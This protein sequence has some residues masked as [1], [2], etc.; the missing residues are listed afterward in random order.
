[1]NVFDAVKADLVAR[2]TI[3]ASQ[4]G[5]RELDALEPGRDWLR[6]AYEE[7]LDMAVY[8]R[9]EIA[10]RAAED[11]GLRTQDSVAGGGYHPVVER[12]VHVV[13]AGALIWAL[14]E[15]VARW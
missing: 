13:L 11:S 6:E 3:G 15:L 9:A 4:H 10:R 2:E 8:L 5:G 14:L 1:V 7:C 12:V